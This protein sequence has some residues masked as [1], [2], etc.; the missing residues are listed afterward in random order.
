MPIEQGAA[1]PT[2]APHLVRET[3]E[4]QIREQD[5]SPLLGKCLSQP[6]LF[7]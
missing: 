6:S 3:E 5:H 4:E 7:S 2:P 1:G